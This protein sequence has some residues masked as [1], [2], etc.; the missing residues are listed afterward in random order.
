MAEEL[1]APTYR[2][3]ASPQK[4]DVYS[5]LHELRIYKIKSEAEAQTTPAEDKASGK[6]SI[7][8]RTPL[9]GEIP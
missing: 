9:Q 6:D 3:Q 1:R 7:H 5:H 2:K 4:R 8:L